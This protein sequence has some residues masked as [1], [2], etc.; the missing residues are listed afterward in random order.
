VTLSAIAERL[1][2]TARRHGPGAAAKLLALAAARKAMVI[3][4]SYLLSLPSPPVVAKEAGRLTRLATADDVRRLA[5]DPVWDLDGRAAELLERGH[6][7]VLNEVDGQV[8]G[9]AWLNPHRIVIRRLR[10]AFS[11][12]PGEAHAYKEFTHPRHRGRRLGV[13]RY[14]FWLTSLGDDGP[15][16]VITDFSFDNFSTLARTERTGL[17]RIGTGTYLAR[18]ASE[19][20]ILSGELTARVMQPIPPDLPHHEH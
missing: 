15:E 9:Y 10:A 17:I 4:R 8:A 7:C 12:R 6:R 14:A 13:D 3:E 2:S 5:S 20:R 1:G 11:L 19:R 18:G 16:R